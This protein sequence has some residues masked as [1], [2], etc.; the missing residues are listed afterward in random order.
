MGCG[1]VG[2]LIVYLFICLLFVVCPSLFVVCLLIVGCCLLVVVGFSLVVCL[3][4]CYIWVS[5]LHY[6]V[7]ITTFALQLS[8]SRRSR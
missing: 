3:L 6:S 5:V 4:L 2:C 8:H 7:H 1:A